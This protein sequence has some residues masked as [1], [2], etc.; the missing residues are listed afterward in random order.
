MFDVVVQDLASKG[1][2]A[3]TMYQA[4]GCVGV[5]YGNVSC[6]YYVRD[7]KIVDIIFD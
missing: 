5:T 2:V 6:Y 7:G 3:Y 1:I 4:N